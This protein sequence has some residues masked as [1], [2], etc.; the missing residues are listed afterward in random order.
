MWNPGFE[1]ADGT[2][3]LMQQNFKGSDCRFVSTGRGLLNGV[4]QRGPGDTATH[5]ER[6]DE[7]SDRPAAESAR[8]IVWAATLDR[9]GPTGGLFHD[10]Q[11]VT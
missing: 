2:N 5:P 3:H 8:G 7:D 9:N 11:P 1:R 10:K 6:G 4:R